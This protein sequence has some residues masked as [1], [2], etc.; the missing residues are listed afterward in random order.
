MTNRESEV[1]VQENP[2]PFAI[3]IPVYDPTIVYHLSVT[4]VDALGD[5]SAPLLHTF[6][7]TLT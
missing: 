4:A 7:F 5:L 2:A 3:P 6:D 1:D